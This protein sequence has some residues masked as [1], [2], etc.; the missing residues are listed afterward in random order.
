MIQ[1]ILT[2]LL[3]PLLIQARAVPLNASVDGVSTIVAIYAD[4][5]QEPI[6]PLGWTFQ[7]NAQ[8]AIGKAAN[9]LSIIA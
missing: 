6:P 7:W 4:A 5:A 9:S 1:I 2:L 3:L 8:G